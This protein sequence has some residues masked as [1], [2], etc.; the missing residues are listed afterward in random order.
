[1]SHKWTVVLGVVLLAAQ[2]SA[3]E[4]PVLRTPMERES[5]GIGVDMG[6]NLKR[7]GTEMN[8]DLVLKGLKDAMGGDKLLLTDE[9]LMATM[10]N[11]AAE[12]KAKQR[13][14]KSIST[15]DDQTKIE[16]METLY[17]IGLT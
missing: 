7:Q 12:R 9:E 11:F 16:D 1:M 13:K 2:V 15:Q 3:G 14:D 6:K 8:P 17:A 10:K 5:Y 4:T